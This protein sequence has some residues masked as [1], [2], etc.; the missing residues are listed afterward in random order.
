MVTF[1]LP[2]G[3]CPERELEVWEKSVNYLELFAFIADVPSLKVALEDAL[4]RAREELERAQ[5]RH[6]RP[7]GAELLPRE[8]ERLRQLW[9]RSNALGNAHALMAADDP[10]DRGRHAEELL[11]L[12]AMQEEADGA[13]AR[14]KLQAG[15][16]G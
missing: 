8:R 7:E 13:L 3:A 1:G 6:A 15:F 9:T 2:G 16:E 5:D 12:K 11:V 10:A 4:G 14:Y